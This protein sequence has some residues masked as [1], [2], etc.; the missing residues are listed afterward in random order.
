MR[1]SAEIFWSFKE[2]SN[3]FF[4]NPL[5]TFGLIS[6]TQKSVEQKSTIMEDITGDKG[7]SLG[8]TQRF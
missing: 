8:E 1:Q 3:H 4:L 5:Y 7:I 2:Y 6:N